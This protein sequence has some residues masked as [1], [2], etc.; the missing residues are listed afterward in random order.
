MS[1]VSNLLGYLYKVLCLNDWASCLKMQQSKFWNRATKQSKFWNR[2]AS[3]GKVWKRAFHYDTWCCW[4]LMLFGCG[5]QWFW[6]ILEQSLSLSSKECMT[7]WV[8]CLKLNK[9]EENWRKLKKAVG[10]LLMLFGCGCGCQWSQRCLVVMVMV[11]KDV[12]LWLS[13][14]GSER[15]YQGN[16]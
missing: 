5:S 8:L 15:A 13:M 12:W 6:K 14:A 1:C 4:L 9:A 7:D 2:V 10:W 11:L 16:K 3:K